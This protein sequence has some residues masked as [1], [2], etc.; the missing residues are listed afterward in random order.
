AVRAKVAANKTYTH[1]EGKHGYLLGRVVF[2]WHYGYCLFGQT[3]ANGHRYY[4]HSRAVRRKSVGTQYPS[5]RKEEGTHVYNQGA[6]TCPQADMW[7]SADDL[8]AA[9]M[10]D[11]F[12]TFGN[13]AAVERAVE[14]ATPNRA[15]IEQYQAR[16]QRLGKELEKVKAAK[17]RII[18]LV[19]KETVT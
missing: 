14:E 8:D 7:V 9:V 19:S 10:R 5:K 2:C 17:D 18:R 6:A 11:L 3:N 15:K 4:R 1:K 16:R 12:D 13:A